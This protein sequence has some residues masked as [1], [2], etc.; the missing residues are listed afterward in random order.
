MEKQ[1][2][3]EEEED[4]EKRSKWF[5]PHTIKIRLING[6]IEENDLIFNK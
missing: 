5:V 6:A 2:L 1:L 4:D 3:E